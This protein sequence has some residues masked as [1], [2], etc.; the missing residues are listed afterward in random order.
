MNYFVIDYDMKGRRDSERFSDQQPNLYCFA[1][2]EQ[3]TVCGSC[4]RWLETIFK[5]QID[6]KIMRVCISYTHLYPIKS[7][8]HTSPSRKCK[9]CFWAN[10]R[11]ASTFWPDI[12]SQKI[13]EH[14]FR[15][16]WTK[17]SPRTEVNPVKT[18]QAPVFR[19]GQ[20]QTSPTPGSWGRWAPPAGCPTTLVGRLACGP[21]WLKPVVGTL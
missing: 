14:R 7:P 13:S 12:K 15:L 6:Q 11:V 5:R 20:A 1:Q 4:W 8:N 21:H 17:C 9:L 10:M 18:R 19:Q 3:K 2:D 16:N